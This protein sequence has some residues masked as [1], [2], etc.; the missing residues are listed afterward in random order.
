M[1]ES[2]EEE[3]I[4][5][6][7]LVEKIKKKDLKRRGGPEPSVGEG[8]GGSK[9]GAKEAAVDESS[10]STEPAKKRGRP[11]GAKGKR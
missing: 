2:E 8:S 7:L 1:E 9:Q 4:L 10:V 6:S 11:P 3:V 5:P